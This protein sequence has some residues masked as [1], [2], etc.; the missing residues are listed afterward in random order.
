VSSRGDR[1]EVRYRVD[2]PVFLSFLGAKGDLQRVAGRCVN[3]SSSGARLETKDQ[4]AI[5]STVLLHSEHFGR[6]GTASVRYCV[7]DGMKYSVGVQ[8][9]SVFP[10]SDPERRKMLESVQQQPV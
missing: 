4:L 8:F 2:F 1:P 9:A 10:L 5:R 7:R 6:M 3:L